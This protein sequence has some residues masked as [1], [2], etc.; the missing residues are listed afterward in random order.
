[1]CFVVGLSQLLLGNS[2]NTKHP[3]RSVDEVVV[4]VVSLGNPFCKPHKPDAVD[5]LYSKVGK[6]VSS[7]ITDFVLDVA[8]AFGHVE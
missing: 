7:V 5:A 4:G 6:P 1:M 8:P 3:V 2:N